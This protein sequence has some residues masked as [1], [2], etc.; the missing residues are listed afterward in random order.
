MRLVLVCLRNLPCAALALVVLSGIVFML[1][2]NPNAFWYSLNATQKTAMLLLHPLFHDGIFHLLGNILFGLIIIGPL[3]E[4]WMVLLTR[5]HRYFIFLFCY[6]VSLAINCLF[7]RFNPYE[8]PGIGF[9]LMIFAGLGFVII[10]Y[11]VFFRRMPFTDW[12]AVAPVG[13]GFVLAFLVQSFLPFLD[14]T[15][16]LHFLAFL[17][18]LV[19]AVCLLPRLTQTKGSPKC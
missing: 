3:I 19:G 7:W 4:N 1:V 10:Y 5:R 8:G 13:I 6:L 12:N 17:S 9:S 2:P 14:F 15:A 11:S 18:G 16:L